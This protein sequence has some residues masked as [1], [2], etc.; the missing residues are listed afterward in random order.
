MP[1]DPILLALAALIGAVLQVG[2]GIGFSIIAG[3]PMMMALGTPVAVPLLLLLNT[4]VSAVASDWRLWRA[5]MRLTGRAIAGCLVGIGL[6]LMTRD[7]LSEPMVLALTGLLLLI[8]V[9]TTFLPLRAGPRAFLSV[10]GL[11]GVATVW[12]ATPGPLMVFG[13]IA[14]G[15]PMTEIRRLVQPIALVAYGAALLLSGPAGWRLVAAAP[16]LSLLLAATVAGSLVG[17][18]F[19]PILPQGLIGVLVRVVSV[20]ACIALFRRAYLLI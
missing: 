10:S 9:A 15:R 2:S 3:P 14:A 4:L 18:L 17:R 13:L 12:A 16:A 20:I 1:T 19:G 7:F 8:G 6:G 11:A 5:E